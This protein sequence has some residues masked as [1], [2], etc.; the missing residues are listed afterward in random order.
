MAHAEPNPAIILDTVQAYQRTAALKGAVDLDLFT[1]IGEGAQTVSA[2]AG[3]CKA[4]ERGIRILC[5][6][7]TVHGLLTKADGLYGLTVD[8]AA[9]LDKRS[10]A[11][12]GGIVGFLNSPGIT[13]AFDNIAELVRRGTTILDGKGTVDTDDPVWLD[14]A[15]CM[16]AMVMPAAQFL[17]EV[18][19][20]EGPQK[21]LDIAAGH[22]MFGIALARRNPQ[23]QIVPV[24]W[25]TVLEVAKGNAANAGVA[26]RYRPIVGDA[27]QVDF[28]AGYDVALV[29]NFLHHFDPP[30]CES[31]LRKIRA[32]LVPG[33]K[34]YTLEFVP[35]DDRVSPPPAATFS[36]QMLAGTP[37]GDAYTFVELSSMF[38]NAGF[39]K[40]E[41]MDVPRSPETLIVSS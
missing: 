21:V 31:L 24:D 27:F 15:K 10:P 9:F 36:L 6:F 1:A 40:T 20:T 11:Y 5:D 16:P 18:A 38:A 26:G 30:T 29:T 41:R 23:A 25:S 33:G 4:S 28:G 2:I 22:G 17:A 34:V 19:A 39:S 12:L 7:L 35:N 37:S 14:F 32:S 13:G 3:S 8:S